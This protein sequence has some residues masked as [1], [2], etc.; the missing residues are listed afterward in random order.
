LLPDNNKKPLIS[1][2]A[3]SLSTLTYSL[4]IMLL[5][6]LSIPSSLSSPSPSHL[7]LPPSSLTASLSPTDQLSALPTLFT[8]NL[9]N[10]I[11]SEIL[12]IQ[13]FFHDHCTAILLT[14]LVQVILLSLF[15]QCL[16]AIQKIGRRLISAL[17]A[18]FLQIYER[19][20]SG[21]SSSPSLWHGLSDKRYRNARD[22]YESENLVSLSPFQGVSSAEDESE[23]G[24]A[25]EDSMDHIKPKKI[26]DARLDD[27]SSKYLGLKRTN[28]VKMRPYKKREFEDSDLTFNNLL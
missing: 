14:I 8:A 27:N 15:P 17:A 21:S 10:F 9:T 22:K 12:F 5:K 6:D 1:F 11:D 20:K 26:T 25:Y 4:K 2:Q 13:Q 16:Y 28:S 24:V 19:S 23:V 7:A 3:I 18:P